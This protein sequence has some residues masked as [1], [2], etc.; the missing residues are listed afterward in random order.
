VKGMKKEK[1]LPSAM[2]D[3]ACVCIRLRRATRAV[4]KLYDDALS[5]S[6]LNITQFSLL[7]S[8]AKLAP[9]T[10]GDLAVANKLDRSTLGRNIRVLERKDLVV[11]EPGDDERERIVRT[12]TIG[13]KLLKSAYTMW[14]V[15]QDDVAR[16]I[17]AK[18]LEMFLRTLKQL[19]QLAPVDD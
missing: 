7:S 16:K 13:A 1:A 5:A 17:E 19:E 8:V 10:F 15:A 18:E 9:V 11:F 4:T 14:D 2:T 12:T 6:G 3:P